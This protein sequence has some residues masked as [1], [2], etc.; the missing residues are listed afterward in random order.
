M[1]GGWAHGWG[2]MAGGWARPL[3]IIPISPPRSLQVQNK[4]AAGESVATCFSAKCSTSKGGNQRGEFKMRSS[5]SWVD[6]RTLAPT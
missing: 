6:D 1:G 4:V 3:I 2:R 5:Y